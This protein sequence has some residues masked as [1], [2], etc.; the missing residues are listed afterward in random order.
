[1]LNLQNIILKKRDENYTLMDALK[2][3]T[4]STK[5]PLAST[6][7]IEID[8]NSESS[9]V[10]VEMA[11][12]LQMSPWS[13]AI[14]VCLVYSLVIILILSLIIWCR[15]L[16][17]EG[18]DL[19]T[20]IHPEAAVQHSDLEELL[21]DAEA[22]DE[23]PSYEEVVSDWDVVEAVDPKDPVGLPVQAEVRP[24]AFPFSRSTSRT[25]PT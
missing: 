8:N 1:M 11:S 12:K 14:L 4:F 18:E 15:S 10:L 23:P 13:V 2:N 21:S 17:P 25:D 19:E 22:E 3:S 5:W 24:K 6:E 7:A 16:I 20:V 9:G